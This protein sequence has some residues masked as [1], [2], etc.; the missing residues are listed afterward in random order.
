[1]L[2]MRGFRADAFHRTE[3]PKTQITQGAALLLITVNN[4]FY[5]LSNVYNCNSVAFKGN[6]TGK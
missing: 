1:M 3:S 5:M 4:C 2:Q 6:R